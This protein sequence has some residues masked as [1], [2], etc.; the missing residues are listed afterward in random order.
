MD[1]AHAA[2][3]IHLLPKQERAHVARESKQ[4]LLRTRHHVPSARV[5]IQDLINK[6]SIM[7]DGFFDRPFEAA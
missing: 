1:D 2:A 6:L 5:H 7:G 4:R 3:V